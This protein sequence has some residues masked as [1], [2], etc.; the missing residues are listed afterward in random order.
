MNDQTNL[1]IFLVEDDGDIREVLATVF[2]TAGYK[3]TRF[4]EIESFLAEIRK[5]TPECVLLDIQMPGMS[6]LDA[7]T[8]VDTQ[9]FKAPIIVLS[10]HTKTRMVVEAIKRGA[11]DFIEKPFETDAIVERVQHAVHCWRHDKAK[12]YTSHRRSAGFPGEELL[13]PRER[14]VLARITAGDSNKEVAFRLGI[15]FRTVEVHRARIMDKLKAKNI[16]DL[17]NIVLNAK[18]Q[19]ADHSDVDGAVVSDGVGRGLNGGMH[20]LDRFVPLVP[21]E[22]ERS[23][24]ARATA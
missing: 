14:E 23:P 1:E 19:D 10:A 20:V 11:F 7:L 5:R 3:L 24:A 8:R 21:S 4:A 9:K 2:E 6:G 15:S 18:S 22:V 13:T 16:A 12:Y 17:V